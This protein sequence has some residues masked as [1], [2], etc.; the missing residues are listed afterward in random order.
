MQTILKPEPLL[1]ADFALVLET[2]YF[3]VAYI[4]S[5]WPPHLGEKKSTLTLRMSIFRCSFRR[6]LRIDDVDASPLA[7]HRPSCVVIKKAG[8]Q[9]GRQLQ[10]VTVAFK[11]RVQ[12]LKCC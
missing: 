1:H 6:E 11:C 2:E 9:E 12:V 4:S 5:A 7:E 3:I 8:R 10:V